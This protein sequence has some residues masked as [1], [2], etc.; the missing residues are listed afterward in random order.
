MKRYYYFISSFKTTLIGVVLCLCVTNASAALKNNPI[1]DLGDKSTMLYATTFS[2]ADNEEQTTYDNFK[3]ADVFG[4]G[5]GIISIASNIKETD[6]AGFDDYNEKN[7]VTIVSNPKDLENQQYLNPKFEARTDGVNRLVF[8]TV[9][10]DQYKFNLFTIDKIRNYIPGSNVTVEFDLEY[11]RSN[12]GGD[13]AW[14]GLFIGDDIKH[15]YYNVRADIKTIKHVSLSAAVESNEFS[16]RFIK[17]DGKAMTIAVSNLKITGTIPD[18][19]IMATSADNFLGTYENLEALY[20]DGVESTIKWFYST[21][22]GVTWTEIA[23]GAGK[24]SITHMPDFVGRTLYKATIENNAG[25][26]KEFDPVSTVRMIKCDENS[27]QMFFDDFG[28]LPGVQER[29]KSEWV[30]ALGSFTY[31]PSCQQLRGNEHNDYAVVANPKWCGCNDYASGECCYCTG[32]TWFYEKYDHT[33]GG[34]SAD[35]KYG[36]MLIMNPL[37]NQGAEGIMVY[38]RP[39]DVICRN[40]F[41]NFSVWFANPSK[42]SDKPVS[43]ELRVRDAD[44]NYIPEA[45]ISIKGIMPDKPWQQGMTSFNTGSNESLTVE[46]WNMANGSNVGNDLLIDDIL[47]VACPPSGI[48][49]AETPEGKFA[50]TDS[51]VT[52]KCDTP[53]TLKVTGETIRSLFDNPHFLWLY[54]TGEMGDFDIIPNYVSS[55]VRT[56]VLGADTTFKVIVAGSKEDAEKYYRG[57]ITP[58]EC[59]LASYTNIMTSYCTPLISTMTR[60]CNS[61]NI[62]VSREAD[63]YRTT[64]IET[65]PVVWEKFSTEPTTAVSFELNKDTLYFKAIATDTDDECDVIYVPWREV[66]IKG[67]AES[68]TEFSTKSVILN[69]GEKLILSADY[70]EAEGTLTYYNSK[71]EQIGTAQVSAPEITLNPTEDDSYTVE[72]GGCASSLPLNV[73]IRPIISKVSRICNTIDLQSDRDVY[74]TIEKHSTDGVVINDTIKEMSDKFTYDMAYGDTLYKFNGFVVHNN[75]TVSALTPIEDTAYDEMKIQGFAN[76]VPE[77]ILSG[78]DTIK[79]KIHDI[80]SVGLKSHRIGEEYTFNAKAGVLGAEKIAVI[81]PADETAIWVEHAPEYNVAYY[82]TRGGCVS[83]TIY[84]KV[85]GSVTIK[86]T[87]RDCNDVTLEAETDQDEVKWYSSSLETEDWTLVTDPTGQ[88][89]VDKEITVAIT[90]DSVFKA[91][92]T[93]Q[94]EEISSNIDTIYFYHAQLWGGLKDSVKMYTDT[95]FANIYDDIALTIDNDSYAGDSSTVYTISDKYNVVIGEIKQV[96]IEKDTIYIDRVTTNNKYTVAANSCVFNSVVLVVQDT[97]CIPVEPEDPRSETAIV[98]NNCNDITITADASTNDVYWFSSADSTNWSPMEDG[99]IIGKVLNTTITEDTYFKAGVKVMSRGKADDMRYSNAVKV[100]FYHIEQIGTVK[101]VT[102]YVNDT[103]FAELN[104]T[105]VLGKT[106]ESYAGDDVAYEFYNSLGELVD[107]FCS[108][109]DS[110]IQFIAEH[111]DTFIMKVDECVANPIVLVVQDTIYIPVDPDDPRSATAVVRNNCNDITI[112]ADASTDDVYWFSS[113]DGTTWSPMEGGSVIGKVLTTTITENTYFKAAVKVKERDKGTTLHY[114]NAVYLEYYKLN[115]TAYPADNISAEGTTITVTYNSNAVIRLSD[116][117]Y[118]GEE[119]DYAIYNKNGEKIGS[120][121]VK[122]GVR[123]FNVNNLTEDQT[124]YVKVDEC[125]SDVVNIVVNATVDILITERSCN[126]VT[127]TAKVSGTGDVV[128]MKEVNGVWVEMTEKENTINIDLTD[129]IKIKAVIGIFESEPVTIDYYGVELNAINKLTGETGKELNIGIGA[130]VDLEPTVIGVPESENYV[131]YDSK[132]NVVGNTTA[133]DPNLTVAPSV[134][135]KYGVMVSGCKSNMVKVNVE[136]PTVFTPLNVDG[137]NDDF[138]M[139]VDPAIEVQ[140]FDRN[141]NMV[142]S[143]PNGWDGKVNGDFAQPGVYFYVAK[144]SDGS[145]Y[146]ATVEIY[147]PK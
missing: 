140:I 104:D 42:N 70:T 103:V 1:S 115:I 146:K 76:L 129:N 139:N 13:D 147:V 7:Q 79:I 6:N 113:A 100:E 56:V 49:T 81:T 77:T 8:G 36:G 86:E 9:H 119:A 24:K 130:K 21:D 61:I 112:T 91:T 18:Y 89:I 22:D 57:E 95:I 64:Q 34:P 15:E 75:D 111:N 106:H 45:T 10:S 136:W 83:D 30:E 110:S 123:T 23:S 101:G 69:K 14:F 67:K 134:N 108:C 109:R 114:S 55:N 27:Q 99:S 43:T 16:I 73:T 116:D 53:V 121:D 11:L 62:E 29:S 41:V 144:L 107:W 65:E 93:F 133:D 12:D 102:P 66:T 50:V 31:I 17:S 128:W 120:F 37:D 71:P 141:G 3:V 72:A 87:S 127:L 59:L 25:E 125:V 88:P 131:Y 97:V 46:I 20:V 60:D 78:G 74:W 96:D 98:R 63:W 47:V 48:L 94:E 44:G 2:I 26:I 145:V 122:G 35:H 33:Q 84:A 137:Y 82:V 126:H 85:M 138:L 124:Y 38:S 135:Q 58:G 19:I 40:S 143:S 28:V 92:V 142:A 51:T 4:Y 80:L 132:G 68:D 90:S 105:V 5:N 52:G 54:K 32:D 117:S 118:A 39:I